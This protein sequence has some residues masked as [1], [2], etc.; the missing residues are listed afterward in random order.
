MT[1]KINQT[2][3]RGAIAL[4]LLLVYIVWGTTYLALK[5]GTE[6]L[7]PLLMNSTRFVLA[8][9]IMLAV[10]KFQGHPWPSPTQWQHAG[11][12]GLLMVCFAMSLVTMAQKLGIGSGLMATVVTT[13]PMWLALWTRISGERVPTS[14]WLGLGLGMAGAAL[15]AQEGDFS[16]TLLCALCA[17][18]APVCWS[19]GSFASRKLDLPAPAMAA[20]AQWLLGGCLA[21]ALGLG[22]E[23]PKQLLAASAASWWAWLYLVVFGTLIALNA[24]LWLLANVSPALAGSYAFVNPAV[25]I[26][27]GVLFG[28]ERFTGWI[29]LA[30]PLIF[31]ALALI[32]YGPNLS[33]WW[34]R[35]RRFAQH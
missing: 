32:L 2:P 8:G 10:A 20:G 30:L 14:S 16:V 1:A 26:L 4:A 18:A 27:V 34:S 23:E 24:Y 15:L 13:M 21:L 29:Y 9:L 7:P 5:V 35:R 11:V 3:G 28:A 17:F 19:L 6:T 22:V 12:V 33:A 25:A 31:G